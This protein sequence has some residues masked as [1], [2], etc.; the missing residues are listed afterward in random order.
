MSGGFRH[1]VLDLGEGVLDKT[2]KRKAEIEGRKGKGSGWLYLRHIRSS[3]HWV[4][5]L[6][7]PLRFG[8]A[9]SQEED[10]TELN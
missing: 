9:K 1:V 4:A 10:W 5:L 6:L 7:L 8:E 3:T 2:S